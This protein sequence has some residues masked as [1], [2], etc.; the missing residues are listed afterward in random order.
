M[1]VKKQLSERCQIGNRSHFVLNFSYS[2]L[3]SVTVR[4]N[5]IKFI[6]G[7]NDL[8]LAVIIVEERSV[9]AMLFFC[10]LILLFLFVFAFWLLFFVV[11]CCIFVL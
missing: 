1:P 3:Y 11:L 7:D 10:L 4:D 2:A 9:F 6:T 5:Q 8:L